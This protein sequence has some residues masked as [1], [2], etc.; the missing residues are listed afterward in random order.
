M[1]DVGVTAR[2]LRAFNITAEEVP[3]LI[4]ELPILAVLATQADGETFITGAA[5]LRVKESDRI[6]ATAR[7]LYRMGADIEE[8]EDGWRIIG[9]TPLEGGEPAAPIFVET[10]DDHRI[11]M[12]ASIAALVAEGTT[13]LDDDACVGVSYP[14]FFVTLD[15]LLEGS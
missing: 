13:I 2:A 12:A 15:Q 10:V 14:E 7:F 6:A 3:P 11:A 4:D 1:G 8:L 5:E 9:P